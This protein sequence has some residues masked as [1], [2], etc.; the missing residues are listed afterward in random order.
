MNNA[1]T[2]NKIKII[3]GLG[4][5]G[6][7]YAQTYHNVGGLYIEHLGGFLG[8]DAKKLKT[9]KKFE[10]VKTEKMILVRSTSF[11]NESGG[12]VMA[13]LKYFKEKP[14]R[15]VVVHD[16]SDLE[17]GTYKISLGQGAAGHNG[18]LSVMQTLG[19]KDFWRIRIGIRNQ[20]QTTGVREK[21][22]EFVLKKI[23]PAAKKTL[24]QV[25]AE[26]DAEIL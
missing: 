10:Y 17:L 2:T 7:E 19:T 3:T 16:D 6:K 22:M 14:D 20:S 26:I 4:N 9:A 21:A 13:A 8:Y 1:F 23:N 18:V 15:L 25:F 5:P 11:M 12:S 24:K